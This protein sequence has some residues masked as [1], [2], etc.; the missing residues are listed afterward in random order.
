MTQG[1]YALIIE[2]GTE[3]RLQIGKLGTFLFAKGLYIYVGSALGTTST[4]LE[5]RL[6]RH[7]STTKKKHWHIDF[8]LS[9]KKV[10]I[11]SVIYAYTSEKMEC[12]LASNISQL[13]SAQILVKK[14]GASDCIEN[15]GSH[16]FFLA[17]GMN[18]LVALVKSVFTKI[19]LTPILQ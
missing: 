15:C 19:N 16:L 11:V 3:E 10:K 17:L 4:S 1:V 18:K 9:S 5:H 7:L 2:K 14:F 8:F 13:E 12:Q 6:R